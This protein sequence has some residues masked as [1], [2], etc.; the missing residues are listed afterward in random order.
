MPHK[1]SLGG[2]TNSLL[3][4]RKWTVPINC[5]LWH[6]MPLSAVQLRPSNDKAEQTCR[7]LWILLIHGRVF[8]C[9]NRHLRQNSWTPHPDLAL[10]EAL[11]LQI[12]WNFPWIVMMWSG[13]NFLHAMTAELC[14]FATSLN[15]WNKIT[16]KRVFARLRFWVHNILV[17][18][19]PE[20]LT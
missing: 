17:K 18:W 16:A 5:G 10:I 6:Q 4:H 8:V 14:K 15:L 12:R 13:C 1:S 7:I 19:V 9:K 2:C 20:I 11:S 3:N